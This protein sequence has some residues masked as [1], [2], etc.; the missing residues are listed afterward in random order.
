MMAFMEALVRV[1]R[2]KTAQAGTPAH[3]DYG[4]STQPDA[5]MNLLLRFETANG[6]R[7]IVAPGVCLATASEIALV[8]SEAGHFAEFVD[9]MPPVSIAE[10]LK[11]R[12]VQDR[13]SE[14]VSL[15]WAK[16]RYPR[17]SAGCELH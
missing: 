10:R 1:L 3:E 8:M 9:H 17:I 6:P 11:L 2:D 7:T 15:K 16:G 5:R 14:V 4:R 12:K 13:R